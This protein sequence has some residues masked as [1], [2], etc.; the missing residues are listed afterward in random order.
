MPLNITT[1]SILPRLFIRKWNPLIPNPTRSYSS[2]RHQF[3]ILQPLLHRTLPYLSN[4]YSLI[5]EIGTQ[6]IIQLTHI[7]PPILHSHTYIC[8]FRQIQQL[9]SPQLTIKQLLIS[10][11]QQPISIKLLCS[12]SIY[13][14]R[15][16]SRP[17]LV[18]DHKLFTKMYEP[19]KCR[20][21]SHLQ[22]PSDC[23]HGVLPIWGKLRRTQR[24]KRWSYQGVTRSIQCPSRE[25]V[26]RL[27]IYPSCR[28]ELK[29]QWRR[30]NW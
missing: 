30:R 15:L 19:C 18:H 12:N 14:I 25:L 2:K 27:A 8:S 24:R 21:L 23:R 1:I 20:C 22:G 6:L 7:K 13:P 29:V 26:T 28:L 17:V 4:Q 16:D 3:P 10:Q 11:Q 5:P 9:R